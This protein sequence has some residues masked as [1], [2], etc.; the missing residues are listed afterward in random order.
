MLNYIGANSSL[1]C[2]EDTRSIEEKNKIPWKL[3]TGC[4]N[5]SNRNPKFN[6]G[7]RPGQ[8][9]QDSHLDVSVFSTVDEFAPKDR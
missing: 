8:R 1:I 6:N 4:F 3:R 5:A 2:D 9:P 7:V